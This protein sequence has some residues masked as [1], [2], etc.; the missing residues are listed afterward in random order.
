MNR[1]YSNI[2]SHAIAAKKLGKMHG[3]IEKR[4]KNEFICYA[5]P[6]SVSDT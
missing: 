5:S 3:K 4:A 2:V 6:M 1:K